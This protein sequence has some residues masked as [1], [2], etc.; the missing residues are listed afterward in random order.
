[1]RVRFLF[2]VLS[3]FAITGCMSIATK[4][5]SKTENGQAFGIPYNNEK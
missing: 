1:M 5:I 2:L 3:L 4:A